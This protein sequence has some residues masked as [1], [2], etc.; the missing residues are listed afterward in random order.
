MSSSLTST[1]KVAFP[2]VS[3]TSSNLLI[4][5]KAYKF[6]TTSPDCIP[7]LA[8]DLEYVALYKSYRKK[9]PI[10]LPVL[11]LC[12]WSKQSYMSAFLFGGTSYQ[13]R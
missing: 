11:I 12:L 9:F 5:L 13:S 10:A 7:K 1:L 2:P 6:L 3:A 4:L 8:S